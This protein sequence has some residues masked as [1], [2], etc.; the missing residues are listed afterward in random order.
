MRR[1][2]WSTKYFRPQ[3]NCVIFV[4]FA[5][6]EPNMWWATPS[7]TGAKPQIVYSFL[8]S[9]SYKIEYKPEL[10]TEHFWF[11]NF[12][13][14]LVKFVFCCSVQFWIYVIGRILK[15]LSGH[16]LC[17]FFQILKAVSTRM[18]SHEKCI[19]INLVDNANVN[20]HRS[21]ARMP[22][23]L[24]KWGIANQ[25][26]GTFSTISRINAPSPVRQDYIPWDAIWYFIASSCYLFA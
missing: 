16:N 10:Q 25:F 14:V 5:I 18:R 2:Q 12:F 26:I 11:K 13:S 20:I 23:F 22:L 19:F 7:V 15:F 17:Y 3:L 9:N 4:L 21:I 8:L 6:H 1:C 24:W